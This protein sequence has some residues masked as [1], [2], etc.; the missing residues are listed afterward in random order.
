MHGMEWSDLRIFLMAVRTG[1]YSAAAPVLGL[2][3]TTVGRRVDTLESALG[4]S[5]F[6]EAPTGPEPTAEGRLLLDAAI[7]IE[8][9][10]DRLHAQLVL[11]KEA[12]PRIRIASSAGI[13]V[14]FLSVFADFQAHHPDA[15]LELVTESDPLEAVTRRRA[16]LALALIRTPPK[17]L[18]GIHVA[19]LDQAPYRRRDGAADRLIGWGREVELALP[20]QWSAANPVEIEHHPGVDARFNDWPQLKAAV[21]AGL[22]RAHLWCFAADR[23][24]TLERL[25]DPDPRWSTG[26]WLLRRAAAPPSPALEDM[27]AFLGQA[28]TSRLADS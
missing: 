9:E 11:E 20:R 13:A 17:R 5:L 22:G 1:S 21:L 27:M 6:E 18:Q 28:L 12:V 24:P 23:E 4:V 10:I 2:N 8:A 3:R 26:L 16:E 25:A 7:R 19:T 15:K 14:E